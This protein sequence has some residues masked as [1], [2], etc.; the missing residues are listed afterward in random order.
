MYSQ[1]GAMDFVR[2]EVPTAMSQWGLAGGPY[3]ELAD[4]N[5]IVSLATLYAINQ[6]RKLTEDHV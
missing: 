6:F 1:P 5:Y 4:F 3:P 2:T